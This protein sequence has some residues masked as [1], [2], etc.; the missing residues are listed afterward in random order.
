M[1]GPPGM[2]TRTLQSSASSVRFQEQPLNT[3][4]RQPAI[5]RVTRSENL[6]VSDPLLLEA[7]RT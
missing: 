5:T 3:L 2:T 1:D 7:L 4:G 6:S